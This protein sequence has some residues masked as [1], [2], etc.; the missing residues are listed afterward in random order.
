[1]SNIFDILYFLF[2]GHGITERGAD[3]SQIVLTVGGPH[4]QRTRSYYWTLANSCAD[5]ASVFTIADFSINFARA[6]TQTHISLS[7]LLLC[8]D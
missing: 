1:M 7:E 8:R 4:Q 2:G 6:G 5:C 3:L